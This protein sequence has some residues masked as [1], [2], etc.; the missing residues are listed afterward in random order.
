MPATAEKGSDLSPA[1]RS[2]I[3]AGARDAFGELGY[4]RTSVD[5]VA[6]RARV[7]K[8]T[9]YN[10]FR[11]K[12]ALFVAAFLEESDERRDELKAALSREP[13]GDVE[14]ALQSIG[15]KLLGVL[16]SRP[17]VALHRHTMSVVGRFP[18]LGE[19]LFER[20]PDVG[21]QMIAAYLQRWQ[22]TGALH[23]DDA[24]SAA[25]QFHQL[26]QG[27]VVGRARLAVD[28]RPT[29]DIIRET[30]RRAVWTFLRA[31]GK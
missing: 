11:D 30:V 4:E 9:V 20:G 16:V 25:V 2:Q 27:E 31:Y 28:E 7:S 21:Y 14:E 3:L 24:R 26:C 19:A 5:L 1:K 15:E 8:A 22:A 12:R 29:K 6:A 13:S 23:I 18:E 10:H 17:I